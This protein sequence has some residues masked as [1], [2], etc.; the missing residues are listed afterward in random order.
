MLSAY[1]SDPPLART[2]TRRSPDAHLDPSCALPL[3]SDAP[4]SAGLLTL[5]LARSAASAAALTATERTSA[6]P[7]ATPAEVRKDGSPPTVH[8]AA[9]ANGPILSWTFD[10]LSPTPA[11]WSLNGCTVLRHA[12]P[13]SDGSTDTILASKSLTDRRHQDP[14][15]GASEAQRTAGTVFTDPVRPLFHR[16]SDGWAQDGTP[17]IVQFTVSTRENPYNLTIKF[18][19]GIGSSSLAC[20]TRLTWDHPHPPWDSSTGV[21]QV[22]EYQRFD[23]GPY[24][25]STSGSVTELNIQAGRCAGGYQ[26]RARY[27]LFDS[28]VAH[29][30]DGRHNCRRWSRNLTD[31]T[32]PGRPDSMAV[33]SWRPLNGHR[34]CLAAHE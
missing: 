32:S 28:S 16:R 20:P 8:V 6:Q 13:V 22:S 3:R 25:S 24:R 18:G 10:V 21:D 7:A 23:Q 30:G 1:P 31:G 2:A 27:G 29:P 26:P 4:L 5:A 19:S 11:G 33:A 15:A 14:L 9:H 12:P 34:L 17:G